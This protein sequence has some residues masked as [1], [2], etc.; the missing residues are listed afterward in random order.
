MKAGFLRFF[1]YTCV[2]ISSKRCLLKNA[3]KI[4]QIKAMH[5]GLNIIF[6]HVKRKLL[7]SHFQIKGFERVGGR[8]GGL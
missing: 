6:G 1:Y 4:I 5:D 2:C 8:G 7:I 3:P